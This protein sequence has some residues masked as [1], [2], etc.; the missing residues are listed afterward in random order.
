MGKEGAGT[1]S[2]PT[3]DNPAGGA[4]IPGFGDKND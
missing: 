4:I 2:G 3:P 1:A